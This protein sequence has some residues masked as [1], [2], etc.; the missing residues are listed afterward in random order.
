MAT[1][2][3]NFHA[4]DAG[5]WWA[6][7][8]TQGRGP[9]CLAIIAAGVVALLLAGRTLDRLSPAAPRGRRLATALARLRSDDGTATVEFVLVFPVALVILLTLLQSVLVFSGNL[10]V[11][12]AAYTA[13]RAAIVHAPTGGIGGGGALIFEGP[14]MAH[15]RHAAAMALVPVSGREDASSSDANAFVA[16][17]QDYY[18]FYEQQPP[19][20]VSGIAGQRFAYAVEHT[21]VHPYR[22]SVLRSGGIDLER[23][24]VDE[25][26]GYGPKDPVAL[27]VSHRLNLSIPYVSG[28]FKDGGF[29]GSG[30][31]HTTVGGTTAFST[32]DA[33]CTLTLEGYDRNLP[34]AP[35]IERV[36]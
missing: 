35:P 36:P 4:A 27:G 18:S 3:S 34:E 5:S 7:A 25:S 23:L 26:I 29:T 12:Y 21:S 10:F 30:G 22:V 9:L 14:A 19:A 16:G 33:T 6:A 11:N 28:I 13:A 24:R 1:L 31:T 17:L 15:V 20:W 2:A 32:I 8:L